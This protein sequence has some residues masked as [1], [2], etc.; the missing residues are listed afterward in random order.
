MELLEPKEIEIEGCKFVISKFPAIAGRE[1]ITKYPTSLIPKVGDYATNEEV[2]LKVMG[3][4]ERITNDGQKIRL[5]SRA[6]VDNHVPNW[7][8]LVK[9]EGAMMEYN[10]SFFQ[11]G[12]TSSFFGKLGTLAQKKVTEILTDLLAKSSQVGKPHS[13]N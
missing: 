3:Y 13:M 11:N 5:S 12:K 6:L 4:V 1:I 8:M 7:E 10:C 9:L 2:M